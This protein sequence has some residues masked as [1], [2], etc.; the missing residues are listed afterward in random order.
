MKP[1]FR[2]LVLALALALAGC[3]TNSATEIAYTPKP[4]TCVKVESRNFWSD[5]IA[6]PCFDPKGE[7]L[8]RQLAAGV[9]STSPMQVISGVASGAANAAIISTVM[10][11]LLPATTSTSTTVVNTAK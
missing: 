10:P 3:T 8:G 4:N 11:K 2:A 1:R 7:M 9:S 5:A 6:M